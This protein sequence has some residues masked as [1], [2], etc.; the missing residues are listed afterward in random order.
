[1]FSVNSNKVQCCT[2]LVV[3]LLQLT[4]VQG[5]S[6]TSGHCMRLIIHVFEMPD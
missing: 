5:D 1:V 6:K 4:D 2:S 3:S